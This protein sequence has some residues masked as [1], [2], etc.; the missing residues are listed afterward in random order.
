MR[1]NKDSWN[2]NNFSYYDFEDE[3][4]SVILASCFIPLVASHAIERYIVLT[5]IHSLL[6]LNY[7]SAINYGL[8]IQ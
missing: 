3:F 2:A 8:Y 5:P 4:M 1:I 6:T 7:K